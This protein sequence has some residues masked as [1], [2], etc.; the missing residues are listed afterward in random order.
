[1]LSLETDIPDNGTSGMSTVVFLL[2]W[3]IAVGD[4]PERKAFWKPV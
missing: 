4:S 3:L 2:S 1:M